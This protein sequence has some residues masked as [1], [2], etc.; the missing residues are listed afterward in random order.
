MSHEEAKAGKFLPLSESTFCILA[1]L[2]EPGHG[3]GIMQRVEAATEGRLR[4]GPGTLYGALTKLQEQKLIRRLESPCGDERRKLYSRTELGTLVT[5]LEG[6]RLESLLEVRR[7]LAKAIG[8]NHDL[9][10]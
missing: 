4:L 7:K 5:E 9:E 3:Y 8:G 1:A 2:E 10:C 6:R